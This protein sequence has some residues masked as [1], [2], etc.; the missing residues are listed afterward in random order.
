VHLEQGRLGK[1]SQ[2]LSGRIFYIA[3]IRYYSLEEL[4]CFLERFVR[5]ASFDARDDF[6]I[7]S[8]FHL[9]YLCRIILFFTPSF[10]L[11]GV[12][13]ED[14]SERITRPGLNFAVRIFL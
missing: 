5:I 2:F 7:Q 8:S 11:G 12:T 6:H 14:E 4:F 9:L 10:C 3:I 13:T 1:I